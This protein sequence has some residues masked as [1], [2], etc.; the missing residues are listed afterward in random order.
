M[1]V[2]EFV[3]SPEAAEEDRIDVGVLFVGAGPA[4]LAGVYPY[5]VIVPP[6]LGRGDLSDGA[7][8]D[9]FDQF[10]IGSLVAAL[11][12]Y[13]FAILTCLYLRDALHLH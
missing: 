13:V 12:A 9:A 10:A 5:A 4:G 6:C 8:L 1:R 3:A 7:V 2:N 11:Q